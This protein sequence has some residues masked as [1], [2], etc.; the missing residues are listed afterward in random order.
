MRRRFFTLTSLLSLLLCVASAVL[1][2][3]SFGLPG[4]YPFTWHG[5]A[6]EVA[7]REGRVSVGNMPEVRE[8]QRQ[9]R[10]ALAELKSGFDS[11]LD[12]VHDTFQRLRY[13]TPE[14]LELKKTT[15]TLG[16]KYE[17]GRREIESRPSIAVVGCSLP[18]WPV[19]LA[20]LPL[21]AAWGGFWLLRRRRL[22][23]ETPRKR[24]AWV[25]QFRKH[26][27]G[28]RVRQYLFTAA[29][30]VSLLLCTATVLLWT[31]NKRQA[32]VITQNNRQT[33]VLDFHNYRHYRAIAGGDAICLQRVGYLQRLAKYASPIDT[34]IGYE[35]SEY[36][37]IIARNNVPVTRISQR[38]YLLFTSAPF[39]NVTWVKNPHAGWPWASRYEYDTTFDPYRTVSTHEVRV[40]ESVWLPYWLIVSATAI[41]PVTGLWKLVASRLRME[42]NLCATCSYDLTGNT[43]GTCPECGTALPTP[44]KTLEPKSPRPA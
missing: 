38:L 16:A 15:A 25:V 7:L 26:R 36:A 1:I 31:H 32:D 21:P 9:R 6:Y 29:A 27:R 2:A 14:Y 30:I 10:E 42:W 39:E 24:W 8:E 22:R 13:G 3:L 19:V 28:G 11:Q 33:T 34:P 41:L 43:S 12:A 20:S 35:E 40:I 37:A 17:A 18:L 4:A 23:R 44:A 5:A